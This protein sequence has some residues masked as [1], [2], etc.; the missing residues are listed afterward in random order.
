MARS[1]LLRI[2]NSRLMVPLA[3]PGCETTLE[4]MKPIL[5]DE[6]Q[7]LYVPGMFDRNTTVLW[8]TVAVY[9][10]YSESLLK[11]E[12]LP[13]HIEEDGRMT[14]SPRG[15]VIRV[16]TEWRDGGAEAFA[17]HMVDRLQKYAI[18]GPSGGCI[19]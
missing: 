4:K 2:P 5:P 8:D 15:P 3:L 19:L 13:I 10:A 18:R 17:D 7:P 9:L 14:V 16:A 12:R 6:L 11:M 1:A